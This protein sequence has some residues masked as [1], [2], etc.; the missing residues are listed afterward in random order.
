MQRTIG[1]A[2]DE[3]DNRLLLERVL[4]TRGYNVVFAEDGRQALALG[5][6]T[7]IDLLL[8]DIMM[9]VMNGLEVLEWLRKSDH[10]VPIIMVTA[11]GSPE[12][13]AQAL[14]QGAD[15]YVTKPFSPLELLARVER[16]LRLPPPSAPPPPKVSQSSQSLAS[17]MAELED[18]LDPEPGAGASTP[19]TVE[20]P[21]RPGAVPPPP[22]ADA[23]AGSTPPPLPKD[24]SAGSETAGVFTSFFGRI[25]RAALGN[26]QSPGGGQGESQLKPGNV[27]SGRYRLGNTVGRGAF[28]VVYKARHM[29]LEM[30]VAVKVL[31][32]DA[33]VIRRGV[34]ALE[35]FRREAVR[36]CRVRHEN[37]VR[38]LDFGVTDGAHAYLVMELLDG[39]SLQSRRDKTPMTPQYAAWATGAVLAALDAAHAQGIIHQDVK[40]SNIFL[41]KE[42]GVEIPKLIDFGAAAELREGNNAILTGTPTHMAPERFETGV[43]TNKGD[44]YSAG[45]MLYRLITG[46]LP[47]QGTEIEELAKQHRDQPVAPMRTLVPELPNAFDHVMAQL[48][49]KDPNARPTAL[50]AAGLVL[51]LSKVPS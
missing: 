2:D 3:A 34:S 22:P 11:L 17:I 24:A 27:V 49:A 13:I 6:R 37:A 48:L 51:A 23:A 46:K 1:V 43:Y 21:L 19:P 12:K 41:H 39:E 4:K 35:L 32:G 44:V 26:E 5:Q 31:R 9:P 29:D 14:T 18:T 20:Q 10:D 8:L 30:D 16:R 45:V 47:F 25:K 38:V 7:D 15:D 40:A 50:E 28:G 33:Q 42:R 36:A